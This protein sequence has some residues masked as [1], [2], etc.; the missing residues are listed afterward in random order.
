MPSSRNSSKVANP[1]LRNVAI[2][3]HVDHGKTTLVDAMLHQS[4]A[5]RANERR[6]SARWTATSSS[7]SAASRFWPRT[8]PST[9]RTPDQHRR[10]AGP[11][12]LRGRGGTHL[13]DGRRRLAARRR[14]RRPPAADALRARQGLRARASADCRHQQDRS[15]RRES[16]RSTQRDIRSVHRSRRVGSA[17]G[18]PRDLHERQ[19][20]HRHARS[21]DTRRRSSAAL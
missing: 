12:R 14:V 21:G 10:H 11:R 7:A 13:V 2:I 8:P 20:G 18:F 6:P 1:K 16:G 5:F 19:D 17:A 3:A 4:G 9:T 15:A